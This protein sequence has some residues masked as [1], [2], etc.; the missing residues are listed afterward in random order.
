[1]LEKEI[2]LARRGIQAY[3]DTGP[4]GFV[5]LLVR[6]DAIDPDFLFHVQDDLPNGGDW[7]GIEGFNEMTRSWLEAWEEFKVEPHEFIEVGEDSLFIS[8]TQRAVARGSGI[9][10]AGEFFYLLVFREGKVEQ[11]RLYSDR[12]QAERTAATRAT[13][14]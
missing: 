3:N 2:D 4:S 10:V 1:M 14:P 11:M 6:E 8:I 5:D 12:E 9:E 13:S 7:P